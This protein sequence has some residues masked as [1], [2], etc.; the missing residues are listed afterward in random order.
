[1]SISPHALRQALDR[2]F[3]AQTGPREQLAA[4]LRGLLMELDALADRA[5]DQQES[6]DALC[7]LDARRLLGV[8]RF[9][10]DGHIL[11]A[12]ATPLGVIEWDLDFRVVEWNVAATQLFGYTRSEALGRQSIDRIWQGLLARTGGTRSTNQNLTKSGRRIVCDWFNTT[13]L[14]GDDRPIGVV[15]LIADVSKNA[16][17]EAD[18]AVK[19][20]ALARAEK[21]A[22]LGLLVAG[23]AHEIKNPLNF[24]NTFSELSLEFVAEIAAQLPAL[25]G[26]ASAEM[27]GEVVPELADNLRRIHE[28][29][30]RATAII[31]SM[32]MHARDNSADPAVADLNALVRTHFSLA[33]QSF[34][35][36]DTDLHVALFEDYDPTLT[37]VVLP[38]Q[39]LSRV[40]L[41]LVANALY[42]LG[43]RR[44]KGGRPGQAELRVSTRRGPKTMEIQVHDN[45]VGIPD[46]VR[47]RIFDP[48]FTTKP[49]GEGTGLGLSMCHDIVVKRLGGR[50]E[51]GSIPDQFTEFTIIAPLVATGEPS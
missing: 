4:P 43:E 28:H 7:D 30:R 20:A 31:Q 16:A 21:M 46:D 50:L 5:A 45:G 36:V 24:I 26:T 48:F 12:S 33:Y 44:R 9:A 15:S 10:A 17:V 11:G 13:L 14:D 19:S 38:Y 18:L 8:A 2:F 29:G 32:L 27:L 6:A 41:N 47:P 3:A 1:V 39:E 49:A 23:I 34:R 42:A 25:A 51:V 35:A 22:S 37:A 40:V